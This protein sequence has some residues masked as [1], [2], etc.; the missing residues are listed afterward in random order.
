VIQ[1]PTESTRDSYLRHGVVASLLFDK[2]RN[3]F[4]ERTGRL[5]IGQV[6]MDRGGKGEEGCPVKE[7][8][9]IKYWNVKDQ[10]RQSVAKRTLI[11]NVD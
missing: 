4:A 11:G 10:I 5:D 1:C 7:R 6:G 2:V 9:E 3:P 8:N